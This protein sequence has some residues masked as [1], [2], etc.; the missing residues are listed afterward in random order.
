MGGFSCSATIRRVDS[1]DNEGKKKV[2]K[3]RYNR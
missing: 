2:G 1:L 3:M